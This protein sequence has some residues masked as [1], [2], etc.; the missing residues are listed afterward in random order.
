[1]RLATASSNSVLKKERDIG[2]LRER[3][4]ERERDEGNG[5]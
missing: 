3:E 1:M 2:W 4:R 5:R